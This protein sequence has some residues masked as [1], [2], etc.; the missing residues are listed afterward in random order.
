MAYFKLQQ[1]NCRDIFS[2]FSRQFSEE[3]EQIT[4]SS[5][6]E[7]GVRKENRSKHFRTQVRKSLVPACLTLHIDDIFSTKN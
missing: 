4:H 2:G 1:G 6:S 5:E 3:S 7:V